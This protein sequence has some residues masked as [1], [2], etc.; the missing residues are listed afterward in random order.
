MVAVQVDVH[1]L[2]GDSALLLVGCRGLET[3]FPAGLGTPGQPV[4]E[5]EALYAVVPLLE[6]LHLGLVEHLGV[7]HLGEID[8][9][10]ID[11]CYLVE[12][13]ELFEVFE[14]QGG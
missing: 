1:V 5:E 9:G 14:T 12:L 11:G 7:V 2:E 8:L 10:L 13:S 3:P 4:G 6:T